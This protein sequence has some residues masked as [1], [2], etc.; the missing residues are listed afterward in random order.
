MNCLPSQ[1]QRSVDQQSPK[2]LPF[3]DA[4]ML[5]SR[6]PDPESVTRT[7]LNGGLSFTTQYPVPKL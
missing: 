7:G 1:A 2:P 6:Y 4:K 3:C 5:P